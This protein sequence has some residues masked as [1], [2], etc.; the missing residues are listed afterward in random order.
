MVNVH[1]CAS[2]KHKM[3]YMAGITKSVL[4]IS[5]LVMRI[6][7]Y[8]IARE[9]NVPISAIMLMIIIIIIVIIAAP[10]MLHNAHARSDL[11][12]ESFVLVFIYILYIQYMLRGGI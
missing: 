7:L 5:L 9:A 8:A 3:W 10:S 1:V 4:R 11:F 2:R 6:Y 12:A